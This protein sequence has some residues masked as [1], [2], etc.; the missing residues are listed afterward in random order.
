[1]SNDVQN[2]EQIR[3][4]ALVDKEPSNVGERTNYEGTNSFIVKQKS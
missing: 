1:M 2:A 3:I 4:R